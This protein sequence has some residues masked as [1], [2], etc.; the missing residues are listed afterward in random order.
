MGGKERGKEKVESPRLKQIEE[1]GDH[2]FRFAF[3][4]P[5]YYLA[6]FLVVIH[7][8]LR[9]VPVWTINYKVTLLRILKENAGVD[10]ILFKQQ[11]VKEIFEV[12]WK[13]GIVMIYLMISGNMVNVLR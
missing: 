9:C 12:I 3:D 5:A 7:F 11:T 10:F 1:Y 8:S 13:I 4:Y 6:L 2:T